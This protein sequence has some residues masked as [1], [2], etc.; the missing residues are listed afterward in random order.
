MKTTSDQSV[1]TIVVVTFFGAAAK[2][3]SCSR[4]KNK[5]ARLVGLL[6]DGWAK[7][8]ASSSSAPAAD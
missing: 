3:S 4:T 5:Q 1:E 7:K 8:S 2:C 6:F